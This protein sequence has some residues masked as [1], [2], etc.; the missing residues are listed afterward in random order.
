MKTFPPKRSLMA[1][2]GGANSDAAGTAQSGRCKPQGALRS[3]G[4]AIL[5][6]RPDLRKG[7]LGPGRKG[8]SGSSE[9]KD[10]PPT[11]QDLSRM[12]RAHAP[13]SLLKSRPLFPRVEGGRGHGCRPSEVASSGPA[14]AAQHPQWRC[15]C[16][17]GALAFLLRQRP[18][19]RP[20]LTHRRRH[21]PPFPRAKPRAPARAASTPG[22]PGR[23][24][25]YTNVRGGAKREALEKAGKS[26]IR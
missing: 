10:R 19:S 23:R 9:G 2:G 15:D 22:T 17:R 5:P 26:L 21:A 12:I 8:P 7:R 20:G 4:S 6:R 25:T 1:A 13:F 3:C 18:L 24:C 16:R 11:D 14:A